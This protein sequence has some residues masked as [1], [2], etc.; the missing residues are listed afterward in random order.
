MAEGR[1]RSMM[2]SNGSTGL[3][4]R[5]RGADKQERDVIV[6]DGPIYPLLSEEVP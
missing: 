3:S 4:L 5:L 2:N 1:V 6:K